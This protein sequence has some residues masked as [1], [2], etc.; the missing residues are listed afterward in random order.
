MKRFAIHD[1]PGIRTTIFLK[2]CPLN[3]LWCHNPE[4]KRKELE[5][6][7]W[8]GKCISCRDCQNRCPK[9]AISFPD[10][11]LNVDKT[12]CE[13]C[14]AC[15]DACHS[16]A[17]KLVG[18]DMTVIQVMKEITKDSIFYDE[19]GGGVTFSGGEPLMQPLFLDELLR[20]AKQSGIHTA[21][22]TCG[23]VDSGILSAISRHV[24]LF[25]YDVKI[26]DDESH[27]KYT[28]V[29][30]KLILHNLNKL[31][32]EG[33][34]IVIRFVLIPTV[35]DSI[36]DLMELA[37]FVSALKNAREVDVLPYHQGGIEKLNRLRDNVNS[38]FVRHPPSARTLSRARSLLEDYGLKAQIGG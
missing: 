1:G 27:V 38:H 11:S 7:W 6:I 9:N 14:G 19:S 3:C 13:L 28:G 26:I 21:V 35:N 24:D 37:K 16:Q 25:L 29:S 32:Q 17:L 34:R 12:E 23:Y 5:F 33:R 30:N 2:G 22:D 31:C 4:G 36:E 18:Q 8:K 10:D 15:A 20:A